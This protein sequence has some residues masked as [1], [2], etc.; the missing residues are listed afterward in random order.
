MAAAE[1]ACVGTLVQLGGEHVED[2]HRLHGLDPRIGRQRLYD[3]L[4][5]TRAG[6]LE[7][8]AVDAERR[9]PADVAREFLARLQ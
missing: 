5:G 4:D 1:R 2:L 7:H 3:V 6:H 8:D 9:D